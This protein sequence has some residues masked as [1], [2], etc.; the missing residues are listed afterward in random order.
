M[1]VVE[2]HNIGQLLVDMMVQ[3]HLMHFHTLVVVFADSVVDNLLFVVV[4]KQQ[5][6][7]V[8]VVVVLDHWLWHMDHHDNLHKHHN[9]Y[10]KNLFILLEK[11]TNINREGGF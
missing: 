1:L 4:E 5:L 7:H 6:N 11:E 10:K 8:E 9:H 2:H 3:V